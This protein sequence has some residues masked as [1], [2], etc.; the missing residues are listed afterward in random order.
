[1]TG[2]GI[3][4]RDLAMRYG[5][6]NPVTALDRLDLDV[7][8]GSIHGLLGRNG[9]GKTTL[10]SVLAAFRAPTAGSVRVDGEEVFENERVMAG[11]CLVREGGDVLGGEPVRDSLDFFE[12]LRETF[13]RPY[14]D[15]LLDDFEIDPRRKPSALSRGQRSALGAVIGLASRAPLTMFDEVHLGM[16]VPSRYRFYDELLADYAEHP[17]TIILSSHLIGEVENALSSVTILEHGSALLTDDI[18]AV[19]QRGAVLT[20]PL[21]AVDALAAGLPILERRELGPTARLVA[22]GELPGDLADRARDAGA[23]LER[24]DLQDL[25]VHLTDQGKGSPEPT[26]VPTT[27]SH[28]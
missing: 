10:L 3:T 11:I 16:D 25:L 8:P 24:L 27:R 4:V 1:M 28:S 13:D 22:F 20:G 21:A 12:D 9:S 14:A 6:R 5:R 19:R 17:R 23:S 26:P 18:E 15:R 7:S 2:Y